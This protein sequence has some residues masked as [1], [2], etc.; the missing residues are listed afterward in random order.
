VMQEKGVEVNS[1]MEALFENTGRFF[2][3]HPEFSKELIAAKEEYFSITGK[4]GENDN[5][6][7][8]RMNAFLLWFLFDYQL[9]STGTVP[10][11]E[12]L[13]HLKANGSTEDLEILNTQK[14]HLHSL[15]YFVKE[16]KD[17]IIVKDL[18][19]KQ[20]YSIS[21]SRVLIGQEKDAFFETRVF[22][23]GEERY[24]ANF[25]IYHPINVRRDIKRCVKQIRKKKEPI[26]PFLLKLHSYH[27]KWKRYRNINIKS[28]YHFDNSV[29]E[30]K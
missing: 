28:I 8:N 6:F 18:Y 16:K 11:D 23:F 15:F 14:K 12:Y 2:D 25:F 13:A 19:S 10:V 4:I 5:E 27:T 22:E 17:K 20:K 29:P 30:A 26:K 1:K 24:F 9:A 7:G 21:D 3:Q